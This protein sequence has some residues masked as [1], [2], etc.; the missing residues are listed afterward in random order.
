MQILETAQHLTHVWMP[1]THLV[2][3][4]HLTT[5]EKPPCKPT[6][7]PGLRSHFQVPVCSSQLQPPVPSFPP[8]AAPLHHLPCP[9]PPGLVRL[10]V[11]CNLVFTHRICGAA[12]QCLLTS[13]STPPPPLSASSVVH[14]QSSYLIRPR[15]SQTPVDL[16]G[17]GLALRSRWIPVLD[18][19]H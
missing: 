2:K 12:P 10:C 17:V 1:E 5:G 8:P 19:D 7:N 13:S 11:T 16:L 4:E 6:G 14:L 9:C 18:R 3:P 15:A